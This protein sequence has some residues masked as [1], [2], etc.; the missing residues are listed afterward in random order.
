MAGPDGSSFIS[1]SIVQYM[2]DTN[3]VIV[4]GR[5]ALDTHRVASPAEYEP[6]C[7]SFDCIYVSIIPSLSFYSALDVVVEPS[8]R[9]GSVDSFVCVSTQKAQDRL[10]GFL[11]SLHAKRLL[12]TERCQH[13]LRSHNQSDH[14]ITTVI[15][16]NNLP[17]R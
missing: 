10:N 15:N 3:L 13:P 4:S 1:I 8:T 12:G 2:D 6:L 16:Y 14:W 17:F 11:D 5:R 9:V 7:L